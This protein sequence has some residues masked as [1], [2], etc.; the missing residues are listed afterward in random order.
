MAKIEWITNRWACDCGEP[1]CY[2]ELQYFG[3]KVFS[4]EKDGTGLRYTD[5]YSRRVTS[6]VCA[7]E[8]QLTKLI[9]VLEWPELLEIKEPV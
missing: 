5:Y 9:Y 2:Q 7:S 8:D 4:Y 6:V 3:G 1:D